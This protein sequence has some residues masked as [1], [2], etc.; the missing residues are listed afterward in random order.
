V[1]ALLE[2]ARRRTHLANG[3]APAASPHRPWPAPLRRRSGRRAVRRRPGRSRPGRGTT[4]EAGVDEAIPSPADTTVVLKRGRRRVP[5]GAR[6]AEAQIHGR[7]AGGEDG[8]LVEETARQVSRGVVPSL[9]LRS[10]HT[11]AVNEYTPTP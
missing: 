8:S 9:Q 11:H 6:V 7:F 2:K 1:P 10:L 5:V 3:E 4:L